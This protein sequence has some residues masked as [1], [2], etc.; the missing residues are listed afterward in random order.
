M[1]EYEVIYK[2]RF[3][4]HIMNKNIDVLKFVMAI[5][6][7]MIHSNVLFNFPLLRCAV[8][9]FFIISSYLFFKKIKNVSCEDAKGIYINFLKRASKLYFFWFIVLLP[10]LIITTLL[11]GDIIVFIEFLPINIIFRST[12]PASWYI[13]AYIIGISI[14]YKF[15]NHSLVLLIISIICY[16]SCCAETNYANLFYNITFVKKFFANQNLIFVSYIKELYLSFPAGLIFI[17]FGKMLAT[18]GGGMENDRYF[19]DIYRINA[20]I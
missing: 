14:V 6:I 16:I 12:F 7:V 4:N 10:Y 11:M 13:S 17:W 1:R 3:E 8:P 2:L 15:R 9:L 20:F 5:M 19:G 18:G